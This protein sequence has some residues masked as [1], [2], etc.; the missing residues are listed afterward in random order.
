[1][2]LQKKSET[3]PVTYVV[4]VLRA[5]D[6]K[7]GTVAFDMVVNGVTIYGCRYID[8]NGKQFVSFPQYKDK[9]GKYW[10]YAMFK[11]DEKLQLEIEN[12][13]IAML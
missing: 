5:H 11:I 2:A 12:Q 13:L 10:N 1:M 6:F 4:E 7:N 8:K 3:N 9:D